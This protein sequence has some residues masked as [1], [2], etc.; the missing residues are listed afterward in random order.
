MIQRDEAEAAI[1]AARET[2]SQNSGFSWIKKSSLVERA[3]FLGLF[4]GLGA[5]AAEDDLNR[6]GLTTIMNT[7]W[8]RGGDDTFPSTKIGQ[9]FSLLKGHFHEHPENSDRFMIEDVANLREVV[10]EDE[11]FLQHH[12]RAIDDMFSRFPS[13]SSKPMLTD[14]ELRS[15]QYRLLEALEPYLRIV[16]LLE[17]DHLLSKRLDE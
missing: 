12:L 5:I 3:Y 1:T 11:R 7:L 17:T 10:R 9:A 8:C 16:A 14:D 2:L 15:E 13:S 6:L 4:S